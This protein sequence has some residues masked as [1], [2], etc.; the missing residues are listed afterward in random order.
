MSIHL[1]SPPSDLEEEIQP[2]FSNE[3]MLEFFKKFC[4]SIQSRMWGVKKAENAKFGPEDFLK[5]VFYSEITGRSIPNASE[6]LN[7]YL[8]SKQ[9]GKRKIYA[10]GRK[11]RK[12]PHQ[13][14]VNKCLKKIGLQKA[15]HILRECLDGQLIEA[16]ELGLVLKKVHLI[17]DFTEHSYYGKRTDKRI[18]GTNRGK[19]TK[20][21]RHYLAFSIFSNGLQL[22]AGLEHVA[23]GQ[24]KVPVII[25]FL[26]H[27]LQLG[28]EIEFVMIDREF[29]KVELLQEIKR[30]KSDVLIPA[31][32][33]ENIK[34]MIKEYIKG[35]GKRIRKYTITNAPGAKKNFSQVMY[36]IL[37]AKKGYTLKGIKKAVKN[38]KVSLDDAVKLIYSVMTTR[39]PSG[40]TSSWANRTSK[41]YKKRWNIE[42][43]FSDL[44]RMGRRW[45]S[46]Y[47]NT[48]Y[49]DLLV[50]MLLYNSWKI[51]RAWLE[52]HQKKGKKRHDW[53]LQDNQD[54]LVE[55]FLAV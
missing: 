43:G 40:D 31:K 30:C 23:K 13:T 44:N 15:K 52:K 9:K 14:E 19:G 26:Q 6:R 39:K 53:T 21:M 38:G 22:F 27:L 18:K 24:D 45:K 46:K 8:L 29:Y 3:Y 50:R 55:K 20:K 54:L 34:R 48:R 36:L 1:L 32:S 49:L 5:V 35:T 4:I 10:D 41:F 2:L 33:Y 17:I 25:N 42:T 47:D 16:R 51:N 11:A 28:F 37:R 7:K 12:S